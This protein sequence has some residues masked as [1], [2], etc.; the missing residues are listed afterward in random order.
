MDEVHS[1]NRIYFNQMNGTVD[2]ERKE[3]LIAELRGKI[4]GFLLKFQ[5]VMQSNV[6]V[7]LKDIGFTAY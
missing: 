4:D 6:G 2:G 3:Q 5:E 1:T 7:S